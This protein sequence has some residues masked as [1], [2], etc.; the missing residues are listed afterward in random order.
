MKIL[1]YRYGSICEPDII[2]TFH[3]L[4]HT[5]YE[6]DTEIYDKNPVLGKIIKEISDFLQLHPV[7]CI[8]S[9]NFYPMLS[10]ICQ[11]YHIRYI[12]WV[13]D[14]PVLE[15]YA[16]SIKNSYN[17]TFIFDHSLYSEIYDLNPDNIFYLPLAANVSSKEKAIANADSKLLEN[18]SSRISFIGSLY[19][20]KCP[21]NSIG[22]L[23]EYSKGYLEAI[24]KAQ[25][26]IYGYYFIEE[27]L[28]DELIAE[29]KNSCSNFYTVQDTS[30]LSDKRLIS[31]YYI[32]SKITSMERIHTMELLSQHFPTTIYTGSDTSFLPDLINRG[33]AKTLT[34][35]PVIFHNSDINL[36]TT[37][38]SI[39]SGIP[40]R[41]W[42]IM[43]S[44]GFA[45]SNFQVELS[46][47]FEL[48]IHLD[49]Y[50][51]MD[52]LLEKCDYYLSHEKQR[53]DIAANGLEEIKRKHTYDIRVNDLIT[54][55]FSH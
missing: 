53:R 39:R 38:K 8:F 5:V 13:V 49:T 12:S 36:N 27:L 31:Q 19:T 9:I 23:S 40:L 44:G 37:S 54:T 34:E 30:T 28:T 29:M 18:C 2:E 52:E 55:A 50:A 10:E 33:T 24:M 16:C 14:A 32:G 3:E 11:I 51:S 25:E 22:P 42:D 43:A 45:L 41:L 35:M 6:N 26:S 48:G 4:G 1:F 47:Y 46:E 15:L 7:D 17:R 20:E 21:Y